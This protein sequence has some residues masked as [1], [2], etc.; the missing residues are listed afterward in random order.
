MRRVATLT[1]VLA[2]VAIGAVV[3]SNAMSSATAGGTIAG[4]VKYAGTPPPM[5]KLDITKDKQVC[6]LQTHLDESLVVG[7][8]GG[9]KYAVVVLKGVKG[10]RYPAGSIVVKEIRA[11]SGDGGAGPLRYRAV[12]RRIDEAAS[13]LPLDEGW[14]FTRIDDGSETH[15]GSCFATCHRQAPYAGAWFHHGAW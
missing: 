13:D 6:G 14:L 10:G 8:D 11:R 5:K 2:T 4:T 15:D 7:S 3:F 12:M 9:I 1:T